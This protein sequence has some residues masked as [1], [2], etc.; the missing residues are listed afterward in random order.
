M[1]MHTISPLTSKLRSPLYVVGMAAVLAVAVSV[2]ILFV[3]SQQTPHGRIVAAAAAPTGTPNQ[4]P[5]SSLAS[6][7]ATS[8]VSSPAAGA[9]APVA[10]ASLGSFVCGSTTISAQQAPLAAYVNGVRTG[11]HPGYDR[12]TIQFANGQPASI[13]LR[14]QAGT[15]FIRS[16]RGDTVTLRGRAG[17]QVIVRGADQHTSYSGPTDLTPG[18]PALREARQ[19]EDF[20]GQVQWGL[21]LSGSGCYRAFILTNPTRLVIDAQ[22]G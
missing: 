14:P 6:S 13:E 5:E 22:V 21:G 17:I 10:A 15:A 1:G 12:L 4:S 20:E 9:P 16:P 3:A 11:S 7:P 19:L 2:G 8:P 18:G